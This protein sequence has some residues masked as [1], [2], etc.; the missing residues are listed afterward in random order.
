MTEQQIKETIVKGIEE[1]GLT[2]PNQYQTVFVNHL[3]VLAHRITNHECL[4]IDDEEM[5]SQLKPESLSLADSILK[6][7]L[8]E[9]QEENNSSEKTLL[10][11][12]LD[13]AERK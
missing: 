7:I 5:K 13:M 9:F 11:I 3:N 1:S 4:D 10:A 12:Y 2:I 6:P 8:A